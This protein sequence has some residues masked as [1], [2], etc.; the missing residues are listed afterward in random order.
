[1]KYPTTKS[2]DPVTILRTV[3]K[4]IL[5]EPKRYNQESWH[6]TK[7]GCPLWAQPQLGFPLCGT[8]SC[9]AGWT[10]LV[11]GKKLSSIHDIANEAESI[12]GLTESE[13]VDLFD[14]D[15]LRGIPHS[16]GTEAYA[17]A[18]VAHIRRYVKKKWRKEL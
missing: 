18:G 16:I 17:K 10:C 11:T 12:L 15:A 7:K 14:G 3:A 8:I 2:E 13:A 5:E 9:V 1:M 4:A 6:L